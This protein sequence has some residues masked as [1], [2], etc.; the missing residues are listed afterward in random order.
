MSIGAERVSGIAVWSSDGWRRPVLAWLDE[1]LAAAGIER[2]GPV[3][4]PH[5]QP[6]ATVLT[7]PTT[8]GPVWLK[9][10]CPGTAS[11]VGLYEF[12]V[13]AAPDSVLRP[14]ASDTTRGWLLLPDGGAPLGE[15]CSGVELADAVAGV[16]R[17]YGRLQRDLA[18]YAGEL[19][20]LGV[21][22]M[23]PAALPARFVT[24]VEV[25]SGVLGRRGTDEDREA[26]RR[27]TGLQDAVAEWAT[28][29]A[30]AP[31]AASIDHNDLHP[32]NMLVDGRF[33]DWGDA[34]VAHPFASALVALRS[35]RAELG[36][37]HDHPAILRAR[38]AYLDAFADLAPRAELV[39]T[40]ELAC[41]LAKVARTLTWHRAVEHED[42]ETVG[43]LAL[44]PVRSLTSLLVPS[45]LGDVY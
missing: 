44:A 18:P 37:E 45:Y 8:T 7:A 25:V 17:R 35:L 16:L 23:R 27:V 34:V 6:W 20:A 36:V 39:R 29:L 28:E 10:C 38:D 13:R 41:C 33:Y 24:A 31:G 12:L 42:P 2:T 1:R 19:V 14:I 9:A 22:D 4:Q 43:E 3:E 11:E 21:A 40:L 5:V 15:R 26:L 32:W 30:A